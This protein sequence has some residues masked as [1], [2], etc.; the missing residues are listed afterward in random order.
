MDWKTEEK[1]VKVFIAVL[2]AVI[3]FVKC[4]FQA[5]IWQEIL[6]Y[7]FDSIF[8]AAVWFAIMTVV[9]WFAPLKQPAKPNQADE[10]R[11][12]FAG[13]QPGRP[14]PESVQNASQF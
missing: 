3:V 13:Q 5:L 8:W 10:Q 2:A 6:S 11:I 14:T 1:H 12:D 9:F 7:V 4:I